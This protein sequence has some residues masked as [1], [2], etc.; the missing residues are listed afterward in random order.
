MTN[1]HFFISFPFDTVSERSAVASPG[2][3]NRPGL[4]PTSSCKLS[5]PGT[6]PGKPDG[7]FQS[8]FIRRAIASLGFFFIF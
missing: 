8:N 3:S 4:V 6:P 2:K 1:K 7:A 5:S